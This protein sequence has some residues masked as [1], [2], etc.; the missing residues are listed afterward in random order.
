MTVARHEFLRDA[1]I[2]YRRLEHHAA[3]EL[4]DHGALDFLPRR[5]ARR[6]MVAAVLL[7]RGATLRQFRR[8]DQH[9]GGAFIEIDAHAVAGFQ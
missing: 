7:E 3:G 4:I 2:F 8:R 6:T 1:L 9:I 5:L